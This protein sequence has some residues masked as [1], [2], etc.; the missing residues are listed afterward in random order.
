[1]GILI[2]RPRPGRDS[3]ATRCPFFG[4]MKPWCG[5]ASCLKA[6][7]CRGSFLGPTSVRGTTNCSRCR[8]RDI[9]YCQ[10]RCWYDGHLQVVL[11]SDFCIHYYSHL[12]ARYSR[13]LS[14]RSYSPAMG[15]RVFRDKLSR[16]NA[17]GWATTSRCH[18]WDPTQPNER[19]IV[20]RQLAFGCRLLRFV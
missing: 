13:R 3:E 14:T 8:T 1:M 4:D 17:L 19:G 20:S 15:C 12:L 18:Y 7:K 11:Q 10:S 9:L 2:I 16:E 5:E 6:L